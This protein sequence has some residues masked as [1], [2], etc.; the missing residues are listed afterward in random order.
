MVGRAASWAADD[1]LEGS[2]GPRL[3]SGERRSTESDEVSLRAE[4]QAGRGGRARRAGALVTHRR[5]RRD[6]PAIV[7]AVPPGVEATRYTRIRAGGAVDLHTRRSV[8]LV[9]GLD[10]DDETGDNESLLE[11]PPAF[12]GPVAGSYALHRTT[13]GAYAEALLGSGDLLVQVGGRVDV[14]TGERAQWSPRAGASYRP[15]GG[16]TRLRGVFG[17]A[18]KLPSFFALGSPP[19]LGGNP[20][21]RS[22]TSWGATSAWSS[23]WA[24]GWSSPGRSSITAS[25]IWW[26]STSR[27]FDT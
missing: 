9:G 1:Y 5:A 25:R 21:L 12:G 11:L 26:T 16:S 24:P 14:P 2:G 15:G 18:F 19:A 10:V 13:A 6:S 20:D 3:G 7:S 27:R 23:G 8:R 22:E 17:R 4:L